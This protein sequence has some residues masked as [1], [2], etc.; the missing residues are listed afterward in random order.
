MAKTKNTGGTH[1][2]RDSRPKFLGV[3]LFDG[4]PA[5]IGSVIVRQRG[6][7]I[8]AGKNVKMGSDNTLYSD[9]VGVIK[10][11]LTKKTS[12][13]GT[14]R[15]AKVVDVLETKTAEATAK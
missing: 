9:A 10:F 13:S 7:R 14:Q 6:S 1:L 11:H 3:K 5:K 12:F 8:L 4:Q 15:L 2:G